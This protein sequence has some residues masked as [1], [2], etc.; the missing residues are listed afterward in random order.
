MKTF[1]H[2][3]PIRDETGE[4]VTYKPAPVSRVTCTKEHG[5]L[6]GL[7]GVDKSRPLLVTLADGDIIQFRPARTQRTKTA[8]AI[9]IYEC[10]LRSEATQVQMAE[11][12]ERK[13]RKQQRLAD[14]RQARAER[15][16]FKKC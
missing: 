11:L 4:V 1:S 7:H 3:R 16:L 9:N 15:K 2:K 10:I 6:S 13:E 14:Q 12:R 8:R 5:F